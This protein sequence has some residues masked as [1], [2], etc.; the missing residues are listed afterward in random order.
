MGKATPSEPPGPAAENMTKEALV[1]LL[2]QCQ[3]NKAEAARRMGK[4]RTLVWKFMKKWN[5]PLQQP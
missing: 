3:W 4:S 5:I 2:E 1:A